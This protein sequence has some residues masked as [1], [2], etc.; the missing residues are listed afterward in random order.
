MSSVFFF[1]IAGI[2]WETLSLQFKVQL[3]RVSAPNLKEIISEL[4][5]QPG[6]QHEGVLVRPHNAKG[7]VD[8][9]E[10]VLLKRLW[11]LARCENS[12]SGTG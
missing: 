4:E 5:H 9:E 1:A 12:E 6:I 7:R 3:D 11:D 8:K 10:R 2:F